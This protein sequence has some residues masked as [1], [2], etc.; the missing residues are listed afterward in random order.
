MWSSVDEVVQRNVARVCLQQKKGFVVCYEQLR[1]L[2]P[3][4]G[5]MYRVSF[6]KLLSARIQELYNSNSREDNFEECAPVKNDVR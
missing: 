4:G 3:P 6:G 2:A 5:S 1:L